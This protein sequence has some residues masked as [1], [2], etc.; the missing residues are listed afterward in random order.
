MAAHSCGVPDSPLALSVLNVFSSLTKAAVDTH[1]NLYVWSFFGMI[2]GM[3][4]TMKQQMPINKMF[5][6][7][8]FGL[9]QGYLLFYLVPLM[10]GEYRTKLNM[11]YYKCSHYTVK[12]SFMELVALQ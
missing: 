9:I 1:F 7:V 12:A 2:A 3:Q 4:I 5:S 6:Y 11:L 10:C 8:I